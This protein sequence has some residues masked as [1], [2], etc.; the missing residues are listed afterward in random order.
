MRTNHQGQRRHPS[1]STGRRHVPR[2]E[3]RWHPLLAPDLVASAARVFAEMAIAFI[4]VAI[5]CGLSLGGVQRI[6]RP[7]IGK[8]HVNAVAV[9]EQSGVFRLLAK[10][11]V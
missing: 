3:L 8:L 2:G 10:E 1:A 7:E 6:D 5:D 11:R 4:K 9:S